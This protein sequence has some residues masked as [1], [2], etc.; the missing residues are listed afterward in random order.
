MNFIKFSIVMIIILKSNTNFDW[1]L[2][3]LF[4]ISMEACCGLGGDW[5]ETG[6]SCD[7]F[8]VSFGKRSN[9]VNFLIFKSFQQ[10]SF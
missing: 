9:L 1:S 2:Y 4:T 5:A 6:K 3:Q 8:N 7:G 10:I